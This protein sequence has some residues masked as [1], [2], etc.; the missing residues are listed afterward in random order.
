MAGERVSQAPPA[1]AGSRSLPVSV[2]ARENVWPLAA[3]GVVVLSVIVRILVARRMP[4]PWIMSDEITYSELAKSFADK[5]R[6]LFHGHAFPFVSIYPIAIAPAWLA[7]AMSTTYT[8]A[9]TLNVLLMTLAA[10]PFWFWAR[11]LMP[12]AYAFGALVLFLLLPAF[13]YTNELMTES[14]A[15]TVALLAFFTMAVALERPTVLRQVLVLLAIGLA[16]LVRLQFLVVFIGLPTAVVLKGVLD[17][18]AAGARRPWR[19]I[20]AAAR[21]FAWALGVLLVGGILYLAFK[22]AQGASPTAVLGGYEKTGSGYSLNGVVRWFALHVAETPY[23]VGL[24]PV[25]AFIVVAGMAFMRGARTTDAERAFLAVALGVMPWMLLQVGA[26]ASQ[27]SARIEE[28][29]LIY[30]GPLFLLAF[31]LWMAQGLPRPPLLSALAALVPA[32]LLVAL[33]LESLLNIS[34]RSD[35]FSFSPLLRLS[36]QLDGGVTDVR[37]VLALGALIA[38]I[39]FLV[40]PRRVAVPALLVGVGA[41]LALSTHSAF[42]AARGLAIGARGAPEAPDASWIDHKLGSDAT[43]V[44]VADSPTTANP[45]LVWQTEFWNRSVHPVL[46]LAPPPNILGDSAAVSPAG[47]VTTAVPDS[48]REASTARYAVAPKTV[49]LAGEVIAET[50]Q[51]ALYRLDGPLRL[52]SATTGIYGDR[53][54]G[55]TASY[56][57]YATATG[58]PATVTLHLTVP[59]GLPPERVAV[60]VGSRT[61]DVSVPSGSTQVVRVSRRGPFRVDLNVTPTFSPATLGLGPDTRQLGVLATVETLSP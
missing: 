24:V 37:I 28:R 27:F 12:A 29:N 55:A 39:A 60:K 44:F 6:M 56:T 21:G 53:W 41:F 13:V 38:A 11:R 22:A 34:I 54:T 2:R 51:L 42:G 17:A 57:S 1:A 48:A 14:L 45:H 58:K 9:K 49:K 4:T 50:G 40:L 43:V 5:H 3:A 19:S 20:V 16:A 35:T 46:E 52:A 33:P 26:F 23:A 15:L 18:Q 59:K 36:T 25:C 30:L 7:G 8:V 61:Q 31:L 32:V 47:R 10:I